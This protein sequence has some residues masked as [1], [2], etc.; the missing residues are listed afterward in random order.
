[1]LDGKSFD[2]AQPG[3]I[4]G[5][6]VYCGIVVCVHAW[7]LVAVLVY[8]AGP[9]HAEVQAALEHAAGD[10][11]L[12]ALRSAIADREAGWVRLDELGFFEKARARAE[13]GR[14]LLERVELEAADQAFAEA[15]KI[16]EQG[17]GWPGVATLWSQVALWHGVTAFERGR[18]PLAKKL[19]QRA[20]ALDPTARLTEASARPDVVRAFGEAQKPR[21]KLKLAVQGDGEL[22]VDGGP[23]PP[24]VT[25]GE[26]VV[27][28]RLPGRRPAAAL[29]EVEGA[30]T[31][32]LQPAP[33]PLLE[34]LE[35]LRRAPSGEGLRALAGMRGLDAVY[36]A[37][38]GV[39]AGELTLV[40]ARVDASGC[41]TA[42]ATATGALEV[43]AASLIGRLKEASPACPGAPEAVLQA[44]AIA[45]P[46]PAPVAKKP[47]PPTPRKKK[48]WER[49]WMW[50]GLLA[51]SAVSIGLA[52]GLAT[53]NTAYRANVDG[54]AFANR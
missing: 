46:R 19:F 43:A 26:H 17:L 50:V 54:S 10:V 53:T 22:T 5:A 13:E 29:V 45:H 41:A 42:P 28:A 51:L 4:H 34:T 32:E 33:D 8:G 12:H 3:A 18:A 39:D 31:V 35:S 37:A 16:Y 47:P 14:R 2:R 20:T 21:A 24:E 52:A 36:V 27:V 11:D 49:P 7:V 48:V 9:R 15:E 44:P 6:S 38:A 30:L 40:G 1:V 23:V 25:A